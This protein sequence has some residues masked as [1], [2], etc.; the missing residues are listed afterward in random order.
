MHDSDGYHT[1]VGNGILCDLRY[2]VHTYCG[3]TNPRQ[4]QKLLAIIWNEFHY[5]YGVFCIDYATF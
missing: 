1:G 5:K 3:G 2:P 4:G